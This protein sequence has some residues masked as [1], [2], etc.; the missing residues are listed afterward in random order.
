LKYKVQLSGKQSHK[1]D[2]PALVPG[3]PVEVEIDGRQLSV[4]LVEQTETGIHIEVDGRIYRFNTHPSSGAQL[5]LLHANRA[6]KL[7]VSSEL[8]SVSRMARR[9]A[10]GPMTIQ[11]QLPGV[12]RQIFVEAGAVVETGDALLTLEAMKMENEIR[13]E[14]S[15]RIKEVLVEAG[16]VVAARQDLVRIVAD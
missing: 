4:R 13:A 7:E 2:L 15:G 5:T 14:S 3:V 6:Y 1:L 8:E 16:Q 11:S 10:T 12:V 9:T